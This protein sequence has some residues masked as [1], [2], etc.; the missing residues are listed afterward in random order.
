MTTKKAFLATEKEIKLIE[1]IRSIKGMA[2]DVP[3]TVING[4]PT[5]IGR[6]KEGERL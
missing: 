5:E 4:E 6:Y 3:I 2:K 1:H